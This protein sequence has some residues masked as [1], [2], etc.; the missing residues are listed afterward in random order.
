MSKTSIIGFIASFLLF[1]APVFVVE[2]DAAEPDKE[3]EPIPL[4]GVVV[5]DARPRSLTTP[6][7][8]QS[9]EELDR[10]PGGTTVIDREEIESRVH[11]SL[12]DVLLFS[13]GVY[14]ES[15]AAGP[16]MVIS[17]RGS[18][19]LQSGALVSGLNVLRDGLSI[20]HPAGYAQPEII[21]PLGISHIDVYRGANALEYGSVTLGGAINFISPTGYTADRFR[22]GFQGGSYDY[23][24]PYLS[25]G[26]AFEN[27]LDYYIH[28][29]GY[30]TD[31]FRHS[32]DRTLT[33][34]VNSN[35]GYR[36]NNR[37]E[38]RFFYDFAEDRIGIPGA[39][40]W[41]QLRNDPRQV[42]SPA[43]PDSRIR[44]PFYRFVL[45]HT[46]KF[47]EQDNLEL[48][49]YYNLQDTYFLYE[50]GINFALN[51]LWKFFGLNL[52]H[53]VYLPLFGKR[54]RIVWGAHYDSGT[55]TEWDF[56][57][58]T[59]TSLGPVDFRAKRRAS[60]V[61]VFLQ[62]QFSLTDSL[63]LIPGLQVAYSKRR[64]K[65]IFPE[66]RAISDNY[67]GVS[68][69]FGVLWQATQAVQLFGN[70]NRSFE[71]PIAGFGPNF[72][73]NDP[74]T[75]AINKLDAQTA[76]TVEIGTRGRMS[77]INWEAA[78]YYSWVKNELLTTQ[79]NP[80]QPIFV[81]SNAD[82]R[83]SGI[84]LGAEF[85]QPLAWFT[86]D[87]QMR[88]RGVYTYNHFRFDGG[89][90]GGNTLPLLPANVGNIEFRYE[91]PVGF[92]WGF[93]V[94]GASSAYVDFANTLKAKAYAVLGTRLGYQSAAGW[95]AFFEGVN[96][97]N[98][99][100]ANRIS[101]TAD[102]FGL[103]MRRFYPGWTRMFFGGFE[104][105]FGAPK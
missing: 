100:Y 9:R 77:R 62:D 87:D 80:P 10:V 33:P 16:E 83:H 7:V 30:F 13:P 6:T 82:T 103:D 78:L 4:P 59:P 86:G 26:M 56:F 63:S 21:D 35:V 70:V 64:Q 52:R 79:P 57:N 3:S 95:S 101:P 46:A 97:T 40:T 93:N 1:S 34:Y 105:K 84:E 90:F 66:P 68:P 98:K 91:Q 44:A 17:I 54:N 60:N 29:S 18:G 71:P 69:K 73:T 24:R 48:G 99:A 41:S 47:R 2:G 85:I 81:N 50:P 22:V 39:L 43:A 31:G 11:R 88:V 25:S 15:F 104:Y 20:N 94:K 14:A 102:A 76:T 12:E 36:W 37:N 32:D 53:E 38:T 42:T 92:Y 5:K 89:S 74:I 49:A 28:A 75:G 55:D 8:E 27:G 45:K 65:D 96:L 58:V 19:I 67:T 72:F 23:F 51:E 61:Q